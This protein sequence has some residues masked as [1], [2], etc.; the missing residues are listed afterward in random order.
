MA[1]DDTAAVVNT[2][3]WE[4]ALDFRYLYD[5]MMDLKRTEE[6]ANHTIYVTGFPWLYTSVLQYTNQLVYVFALTVLTLSF[7][8]YWYFH[9]WTGISVPIFSGILSRCLGVG[10]R[11]RSWVQPRS[12][13]AGHSDLPDRARARAIPCSRWTA[14]TTSTIG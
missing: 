2:G 6:D 13:R 10:N 11:R 3:F 4:E 5:R 1:N 9:T 12:A 8:L 7:L 14:T